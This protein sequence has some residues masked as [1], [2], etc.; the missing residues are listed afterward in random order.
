MHWPNFRRVTQSWVW[1]TNGYWWA[2]LGLFL[3][4]GSPYF[5]E[6]YLLTTLQSDLQKSAIQVS[7][8]LIE[9]LD[10]EKKGFTRAVLAAG[11]PRTQFENLTK[12]WL[13]TASDVLAVTL[14]DQN[15]RIVQSAT[16]PTASSPAHTEFIASWQALNQIAIAHAIELQ[17]PAFT[18][19]QQMQN[20]SV[21]NL[22]VPTGATSPLLYVL[23]LDTQ[24]W[25]SKPAQEEDLLS[26]ELVPYRSDSSVSYGRHYI[27]SNAWEGLWSLKFQSR[28]PLLGLLQSLRP[29]FFV[30]TWL[31]VGMFFLY[32]R[33]YRLRQKAELELQTK[34]QMLEKQNRL[35][36][37][38]E[39][40][41]QLAHEINQPLATIANYAVAGKLQ[42]QNAENDGPLVSLFEEILEQ[43]Q[44][45]AQVLVAVRAILQPSPMDMG[46]VNVDELMQKLEP[47]LRFLCAPHQVTLQVV[48]TKSLPVRLNTILFEQVIFNMVK[49][50][51]QSL[52]NSDRPDKRI[53]I[54]CTEKDERLMIEIEDNGPG[55]EPAHVPQIFQ[56]FFTTKPEG[57]GIGLSLCRSVIERF[58][59]RLTLKSN[60]HRGVCFLIELPFTNSHWETAPP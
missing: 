48:R 47:S 44:R 56:S 46:N 6:K 3:L 34:S 8:Q 26:V 17:E 41:A 4:V 1:R 54:S 58:S 25:I 11:D 60:S 23:T 51:I 40:S 49:N 53:S 39:M 16:R 9:R 31:L 2:L 21:V 24:Q 32:W 36:L 7:E 43:S 28:D 42:L 50:S 5:V 18:A 10:T 22:V 38:G 14:M 29:V 33:N 15:G 12:I 37:L 57:L 13:H 20:D 55:I 35:S 59:G 45:A 27:N 19:L 52:S 30:L